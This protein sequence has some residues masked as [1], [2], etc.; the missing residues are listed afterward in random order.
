MSSSLDYRVTPA[1][2][3]AH[4]FSVVLSVPSPRAAGETLRLPAWIP[5]SYMI[6]EFARNIVDI[7]ASQ[8]RRRVPLNKV[9]K[10][11]WVTGP[12]DPSEPLL[13]ATLV[14]AWDLSVRCAHLDRS[15]GFFNGT[16]LFLS[17]L[18]RE[19]HA[20]RVEICRPSGEAYRGW[21]LATTLPAESEAG[22][23][24]SGFGTRVAAGYDE[25]IDHPVEMGDFASLSFDVSGVPHRMV[26]T[27]RARFDALRLQADLGRVCA[28]VVMLFGEAP[29]FAQ[30]LFMVMA[31]GDGYGGL[32]HRSSTALLCARND[33][34]VQRDGEADDAYRT[35][36]GLCA[37]E[38]FHAWHVKR[39]KPEAFMPYRLHE[40]NYTRLLWVFEGFTSYYDDLTLVRA[41]LIS[42]EVYLGLIAKTITGV[43]R[44]SGRLRQTLAESSFDAWTK[45]YRQDENS[46]NAIV[47][48]YQKGALVAFGLDLTIRRV[49]K[50]Q[51]SLD[52][53]MRHLWQHYGKPGRGVPE[54]AMPAIIFAATGVAVEAQIEAWVFGHED[55]PFESLFKA[56]GISMTKKAGA[57]V[58]GL[59]VRVKPRGESLYISHVL[60][61]GSAQRAGLSAG[62]EL[63]ALDGLK[64]TAEN[65]DKLLA[66]CP[67][68]ETVLVTV[69][70]RDELGHHEVVLEPP[71]VEDCQLGA[72]G[73]AS[74]SAKMLRSGWLQASASSGR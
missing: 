66:R 27:G 17:V 72:A 2:P 58:S 5:G 74:V 50:G 63:V 55:V 64:V 26:V 53:V 43:E 57:R 42:T 1:S 31:V 13:I 8:A 56:F 59:G 12:L 15:H 10:H 68:N 45:Y 73:K 60:D 39:I 18:G 70:R 25:L 37:H 6:R 52:D 61:G 69:F 4:L 44:G 62:D 3:D 49:T 38:Y 23:D 11:S 48:Y 21:K 29:P 34:P 16:Q 36:L 41:G 46:P 28:E 65:F 40:E 7:K 54:D 32:E 14:Y 9:D 19:H 33:L 24:A 51:R 67:L 47:S 22:V 30:Y 20:H 35:F 71:A